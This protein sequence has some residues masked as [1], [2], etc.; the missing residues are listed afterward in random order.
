MSITTTPPSARLNIDM[1]EADNHYYNHFDGHPS[2]TFFSSL[3][4]VAE[5]SD[6]EITF[7]YSHANK[8][9]HH[10]APTTTV[11][12]SASSFIIQDQQNTPP[13]LFKRLLPVLC[14]GQK[15]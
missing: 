7:L 2:A 6:I 10:K 14:Q 1:K 11:V 12:P 3:F 9:N 4:F 8:G 5:K 13:V 15:N